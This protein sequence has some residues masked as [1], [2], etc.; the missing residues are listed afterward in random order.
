MRLIAIHELPRSSCHF[1]VAKLCTD[2]IQL[3]EG[4]K[5][6]LSI[7]MIFR[8]Q[9]QPCRVH[10]C[11]QDPALFFSAQAKINLSQNTLGVR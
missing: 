8:E 3:L 7:G 2:L 1:H 6:V 10:L 5:R 11:M 9:F 4:L